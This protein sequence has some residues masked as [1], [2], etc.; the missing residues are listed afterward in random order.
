MRI[1]AFVFIFGCVSLSLSA[2]KQRSD[3]SEVKDLA[4]AGDGLVCDDLISRVLIYKD[5]DLEQSEEEFAAIKA[6][7][8]AALGSEVA[9]GRAMLAAARANLGAVQRQQTVGVGPGVHTAAPGSQQI[10]ASA[11]KPK[12]VPDFANVSRTPSP[13]DA[14]AAKD[15]E[16]VAGLSVGEGGAGALLGNALVQNVDA[17]SKNLDAL[18]ARQ[19][20]M[21]VC[22]FNR[23]KADELAKADDSSLVL[24]GAGETGTALKLTE[25]EDEARPN[26]TPAQRVEAN[27]FITWF[28]RTAFTAHTACIALGGII[29]ARVTGNSRPSSVATEDCIGMIG[30]SMCSAVIDVATGAARMYS[31]DTATV[32]SMSRPLAEGAKNTIVRCIR[33]ELINGWILQPRPGAGAFSL[34]GSLATRV[35]NALKNGAAA[36]ICDGALTAIGNLMENVNRRETDFQNACG[37][38]FNRSRLNS[39]VQT[40]ASVCRAAN[41]Q[42][43]LGGLFPPSSITGYAALDGV[44]RVSADLTGSVV[45]GACQLGGRVTSALCGTI[46]EAAGQISSALR[47]GNNDWSH[48]VGADQ[49]GVCIGTVYNNWAL[50][51]DVANAGRRPFAQPVRRG[52]DWDSLCCMCERQ[53]WEDRFGPDPQVMR[54]MTFFPTEADGGPSSC[55]GMFENMPWQPIAAT[56]ERS[57]NDNPVYYGYQ[58][59]ARRWV[60]GRFCPVVVGGLHWDE[61]KRRQSAAIGGYQVW[62][63]ATGPFPW[64]GRGQAPWGWKEYGLSSFITWDAYPPENAGAGRN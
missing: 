29:G 43:N 59:C 25:P 55:P 62:D 42:V 6:S 52:D 9:R 17:L 36:R 48:C 21:G 7:E 30:A 35:T 13:P 28:G 57:I 20:A 58:N 22:N 32:S 27:D 33:S 51:Y 50:G 15:L 12:T 38:P 60:K 41:G 40:G 34:Q 19:R 14:P 26:L 56:R 8:A 37:F 5:K 39:C 31:T 61:N 47:T 11:P 3:S 54:E 2:C 53:Y 16:D 49:M 23:T 1:R 24:P 46:A 63:N 10:D 44:M 4:P 64:D 18:E 45:S